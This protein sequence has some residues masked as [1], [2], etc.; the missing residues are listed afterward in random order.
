MG[1]IEYKERIQFTVRS[2]V[3]GLEL[4]T[5]TGALLHCCSVRLF[6]KHSPPIIATQPKNKNK[7]IWDQLAIL[8][9]LE[10]FLNHHWLAA[11]CYCLSVGVVVAGCRCCIG[12]VVAAPAST[13]INSAL[14]KSTQINSVLFR[15]N[16]QI[17]S[18]TRYWAAANRNVILGL[19]YIGGP[20]KISSDDGLA[21]CSAGAI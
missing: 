19:I 13:Q 16:K 11:A 7:E 10:Q 1:H 2:L 14:K 4:F 17:C 8:G 6:Q 5:S 20:P 15:P 18:G 12:C 3:S 9:C 21:I